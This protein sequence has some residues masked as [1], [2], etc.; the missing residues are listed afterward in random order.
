[1]LQG[2]SRSGADGIL[3][4]MGFLGGGGRGA[5]QG[6]AF[7]AGTYHHILLMKWIIYAQP[8]GPEATD[9]LSCAS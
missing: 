5:A 4:Q 8:N 2:K 6:G 3:K 1:M 9:I 7:P